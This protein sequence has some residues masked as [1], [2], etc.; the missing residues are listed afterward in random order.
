MSLKDRKKQPTAPRAALDV[1]RPSRKTT[2]SAPAASPPPPRQEDD[3]FSIDFYRNF[4]G[5]LHD[6]TPAQAAA[7]WRTFGRGEDRFPNAQAVIDACRRQGRSLP[8]DFDGLL[9]HLLNPHA[10]PSATADMI[11]EAHYLAIGRDL[12]LPY[13]PEDHNFVRDLY[14]DAESPYS[15]NLRTEALA[16]TAPL[17]QSPRQ[18]LAAAGIGATD[19]LSA[20]S[21]TDYIVAHGGLGL[22]RGAQ[23][24]HHFVMRGLDDGAP[25]RF[26][27]LFDAA[28]YRDVN[29]E[30]ADLN[31]RDVYRHWLNHGL[32]RDEPPNAARFL[33]KLLL[34]RTDHYPTGFNPEIYA[35]MNPDL[36]DTVVGP[37]RLLQHCIVHGIVE[38]R[39][40]TQPYQ[41][42]ADLFRAAADLQAI[43]GQLGIAQRLYETTLRADPT[44]VT[45]RRHYADCLFR[46]RNFHAAAEQFQALMTTGSDTIWT[47]L[48]LATC[49]IELRAWQDAAGTIRKLAEQRPGDLG[50]QRRLRDICRSGYD[51]L[52]AEALWYAEHGFEN[53]ARAAIAQA[54]AVLDCLTMHRDH[55]ETL[56]TRPLRSVAIVADLGLSQCRFYRVEQKRAQLETLGIESAIFDFHSDT[57]AFLRRLSTFDAVIFYR[58]TATPDIVQAIDA[59]RAAG[60]PS[61]YEIDDLM[62]DAKRFP[63]SFESYGGQITRSLYA[64]L[65]IAPAQLRAAMALCD[66]A[67]ASTPALARQMATVLGKERVFLHRNALHE[68]HEALLRAAPPPASGG[69]VKIFYGSGTKAHNEDFDAFAAPALLRVLQEQPQVDLVIVGYLTLPPS[70]APFRSRITRIDPIWDIALYWQVM[71]TADIAIAVLKPGLIADCKSE[72]KWLEAALLAIPS[73]VTAT[74]TYREVVEAGRTGLLATTPEEWHAALTRLVTQPELRRSI[75]R[76]ARERVLRG[77]GRPAMAQ[78]LGRLLGHRPAALVA[79]KGRQRLLLVNVFFPPQAVGGATRV[80]CDNARDLQRLFPDDVEIEIFTTLEGSLDPYRC[81]TTLWQGVP[82][83]S[84][85]TPD[86]PAIDHRIRDEGMVAAFAACVDRFQPDVIHFHCLQRLT[87]AICEVPLQR[88]I[89]YVI[90]AHDGW[91]ISDQQFLV[92][93]AGVVTL[94]DYRHPLEEAARHGARRLARMQ[95][96][97]QVIDGAAEF[98]TVS[99]PFAALHEKAGLRRP[100]VIE[101]GLPPI[102]F[103]PRSPSATGR[104][105]LAHIGGIG[106]HKGYP[107]IQSAL[108]AEP[109]RHLEL[110]VIDHAMLPGQETT[111]SWGTT[112]VTFRGKTPQSHIADLYRDIDVLLAPSVWPES[113]GLV[114]REALQ[115]GC[116]VVTSDRGAIGAPV[117]PACGFVVP[118][119]R[120][121]ALRAALRDIDARPARY[122]GPL[123]KRPVLR[124]A[125]DQAR[126]LA[127]LYAEVT[128]RPVAQS[129]ERIAAPIGGRAA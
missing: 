62:F 99:A 3:G 119:D 122:L 82:V 125:E 2:R 92:D 64:T 29:R 10:L 84:V 107:L 78:S 65:V 21:T 39:S 67:V 8:P 49:L 14:L 87:A 15:F 56:P 47:Y 89:P 112:P 54:M 73:V 53:E 111:S 31:D 116:W 95:L 25:I 50:V 94:Y 80:V 20:F 127:A 16:G 77:Y 110:L 76:A 96:L 74:E 27:L 42:N 97:R 106:L 5:D 85:T 61:F 81:A 22:R 69:R 13:R 109:F 88:K 59:T 23:C 86:D 126:A 1:A 120:D 37:W 91:W 32:A 55:L 45:A 108:I 118:V 58:V 9:Y 7:H 70:F 115:A 60:K 68:P 36:A 124:P 105:R 17:F 113:F 41:E 46:Q 33:G 104:V 40:G 26:D 72:I 11:A 4:Y 100:R 98:L 121:D 30:L 75:G 19:I 57:E 117:T 123:E 90:T 52:R 51:A 18:L 24:L 12:G 6:L 114:V 103:H 44:H 48:N 93:D 38:E 71:A 28:F 35:A 128:S 129:E 34:H 63:D 79:G 83:Q 43:A 66:F 101:N 102:T